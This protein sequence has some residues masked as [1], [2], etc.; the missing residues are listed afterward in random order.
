MELRDRRAIGRRPFAVGAAW[1][2]CGLTLGQTVAAGHAGDAAMTLEAAALRLVVRDNSQSPTVLGGIDSLVNIRDEPAFDA[3]DPDSKGASAGA[4]FEHIIAGHRSEHNSFTPRRG[5]TRLERLGSDAVAIVRDAA[6]EPWAIRSRLHYR[7]VPPHYVDIDFRCIAQ[8]ASK[9]GRHR[10]AIFFFANYMNEV[11]DIGLN[12]RGLAGP[13]SREEWLRVDAPAGHADWNQGGTYRS[14]NAA[15]LAYDADHNFRLNSWS[16]EFPRF[17]QP[18]FFGRAAKNMVF[19]MMFDRA[20]TPIDEIRFSIFKF[21][22]KRFPRPAWDY[23]YVVRNLE[24]GREYGFRA[25]MIWKRFVSAEDCE[26]E[27]A[28]WRSAA[29]SQQP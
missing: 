3:F 6:D 13:N 10:Y 2:L 14:A 16:Y 9:F 18:F 24:D 23:Q 19:Q 29:K 28:T 7:I 22:L 17:T 11:A 27:W 8:D 4:N 21:K 25:R 15:P 5:K 1:G 20:H 12:F 26:S